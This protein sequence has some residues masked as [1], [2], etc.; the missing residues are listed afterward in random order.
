MPMNGTSM[1]A[2]HVAGV[3]ALMFEKNPS[4][5]HNQLR[6]IILETARPPGVNTS[7]L[8]LLEFSAGS[9]F[10]QNL[11][12]GND[13]K[14]RG[15]F[16]N[17]GITLSGNLT[18]EA[19]ISGR[20]WWVTDDKDQRYTV[21][22]ENSQLKVYDLPNNKWGYGKL[23]A[24]RAVENT[25]SPGGNGGGG[26]GGGGGGLPAPMVARFAPAPTVQ[27]PQ[28]LRAG[29]RQVQQA[30]LSSPAGHL[31][32]GL[33]STHFDEVF[34]LIQ[35]NRRVATLW[36]RSQGPAL[37]RRLLTQGLEGEI[38]IPETIGDRPLTD[39]LDRF[40]ALLS[41]YGS[42]ALQTDIAR[43]GPLF[44]DAAGKSLQDLDGSLLTDRPT[45]PAE[46]VS[47]QKTVSL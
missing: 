8:S 33:I 26:G 5:H 21:I 12:Q 6:E 38:F 7:D 10:E 40:L 9:S 14:I 29:L 41:R 27:P 11:N 39:Q 43:Y 32:A 16:Q 1:A 19:V 17:H 31:I 28:P 25:P 46:P 3:M 47:I 4:L 2:P 42:P 13:S 23:D 35:T 37:V 36:H 15:E 22:K 24:L 34:R 30:L 44:T 18:I 45:S 20:R